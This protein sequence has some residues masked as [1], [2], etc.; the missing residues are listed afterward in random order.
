MI[1]QAKDLDAH[2]KEVNKPK[3]YQFKRE[4][5]K[6][7]S[8]E[9]YPVI[10]P[11]AHVD[12]N[13][14]P[15]YDLGYGGTL[16]GGRR[17]KKLVKYYFNYPESI[18]VNLYGKLDDPKLLESARKHYGDSMRMPDLGTICNFVDNGKVLNQSLATIVIGDEIFERTQTVQQRAW[19]A[20]CANVIAF[21]DEDLDK[22]KTFY[23]HDDVMKRFMYVA[24]Q[25]DV[26]KRIE[27]LRKKPELR[28]YILKK[29]Q[30]MA[31]FN[32]E[33]WANE[34]ANDIIG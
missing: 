26:I 10:M 22:D 2:L 15:K 9:K 12:R 1:T 7:F 19:Q 29:Q 8:F 18:S 31:S 14:S 33:S 30:E 13:E 4:Q 16:R 11:F 24:N 28:D 20:I 27:G 3:M 5:L 25:D 21:V 32:V 34:L 6:H 17:I 23:G